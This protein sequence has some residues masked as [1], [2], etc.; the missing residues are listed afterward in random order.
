M[1]NTESKKF[2]TLVYFLV[3]FCGFANLAIEIIGPRLFASLFG[4]TTE[5]WAIIISVTLIGISAGYAIGGRINKKIIIKIIP[6]I[7]VFNAF[8]LIALS[9]IIWKLPSFFIN[10]ILGMNNIIIITASLS[11]FIP[12]MLFSMISPLAISI[13]TITQQRIGN[14]YA[15]GTIG[16]VAGALSAAFWFIPWVGL[17]SSLRAFAI[18]LIILALFFIPTRIKFVGLICLL[19]V[20]F[21]PLPTYQWSDNS[22]EYLLTQ[23]EGYYQTIRVYSDDQTFIRMHLGPTYETKMSMATKEPLFGYAIQMVNLIGDARD[24]KILVIGGAGHTQARALERRGAFVTEVEIDPIVAKISDEYFGKINGNVI[25]QDGRAFLEQT[26]E[27]FDFILVDAYNGPAS[28]P[29]QLT[30][31]EFFEAAKECLSPD[32]SII[33]NFI[34]VPSGPKS[35]SYQAFSATISSAFQYTYVSRNFGDIP[36]NLI[37]LGS[38]SPINTNFPQ[39]PKNGVILTDERNPIEIYFSEARDSFYF[40]K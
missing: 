21:L 14:I 6:I 39:P 29:S 3:F 4:N 16:S 28:I 20:F 33:Y 8:W 15:V 22:S 7:L 36:M 17:S 9:W 35:N 27:K 13:L 38:K 37:F 12:S 26:T 30:T 19:L 31:K 23:L 2:K 40:H 11:F 18:I 32:G 5:I 25:I 1:V 24:K 10:T 34:G